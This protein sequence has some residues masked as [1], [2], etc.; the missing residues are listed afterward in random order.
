[1]YQNAVRLMHLHKNR[2]LYVFCSLCK[3]LF[4]IVDHLKENFTQQ[5]YR[6]FSF[7]TSIFTFSFKHFSKLLKKTDISTNFYSFDLKLSKQI[8]NVINFSSSES[9]VNQS[10]LR[11]CQRILNF[12]GVFFFGPPDI[13][14][15]VFTYSNLTME[16]HKQCMKSSQS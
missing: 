1:M 12:S 16:T 9:N 5:I 3:K 6:I 13:T 8:L 14:Q 4:N 11:K 2:S 15:L 10:N 7:L